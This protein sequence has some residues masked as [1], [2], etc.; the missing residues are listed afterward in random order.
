MI[1][2]VTGHGFNNFHLSKIEAS[3]DPLCRFCLEED[4]ETWHVVM[5]CVALEEVR[6][7]FLTE[8]N[9]VSNLKLPEDLLRLPDLFDHIGSLFDHVRPEQNGVGSDSDQSTRNI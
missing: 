7:R 2:I 1:Q 8:G 5:E 4:E 9:S 3:H 6:Y